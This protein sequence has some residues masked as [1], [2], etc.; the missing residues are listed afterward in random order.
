MFDVKLRAEHDHCDST[1]FKNFLFH[2]TTFFLLIF[3]C[4]NTMYVMLEK[5]VQMLYWLIQ[6][7]LLMAWHDFN[8]LNTSKIVQKIY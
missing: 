2:I 1:E 3:T 5:T 7:F 8:F 4:C 6:L